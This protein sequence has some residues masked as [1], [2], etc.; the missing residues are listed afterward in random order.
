MTVWLRNPQVEGPAAGHGVGLA[1]D[2]LRGAQFAA[3]VDLDAACREIN[4][5][6][7]AALD[8]ARADALALVEDAR[9]Q[10][11]ALVAQ[12][13]DDFAAASRRGYDDGLR[14]ALADWHTRCTVAAADAQSLGR[15]QRERLAELV[16][17]AVEQIVAS[18]EPAVLFAR[19]AASVERIVADGSPVRVRVHPD[20][21]AAA[22]T[23]FDEAAHGWRGAGR[24]VRLQVHA[25]T[26]LEAG[27]CVCES[28]L[29]AVDASLALQLAA[30][31][32]ALSRAVGSVADEPACA[33]E[34]AE[35]HEH[36]QG[37]E[38]EEEHG[39]EPAECLAADVQEI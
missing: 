29:G 22:R 36:E 9:A 10:A 18:T 15:R 26:A 21:L 28:D 34:P 11:Q 24:A 6:C 4:E 8:A 35:E 23:A 5:R 39:Q 7:E 37:P 32:D 13:Q 20:D 3:V 30:I 2:V 25:D 1:D 17:L 14:N 16:A 31:R 19:A 38:P 33:R 12:A 27:A